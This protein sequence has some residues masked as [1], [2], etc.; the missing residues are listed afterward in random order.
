MKVFSLTL[1]LSLFLLRTGAQDV[2]P[3][4]TAGTELQP[5]EQHMLFSFPDFLAQPDGMA[6]DRAGNVYVSNPNF[7][8]PEYPGLLLKITQS[9]VTILTMSYRRCGVDIA[10]CTCSARVYRCEDRW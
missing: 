8:N 2:A 9:S 6:M 10:T 5:G 1:I 4:M 3:D 7:N